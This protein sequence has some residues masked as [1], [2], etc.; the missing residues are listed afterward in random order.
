MGRT[1]IDDVIAYQIG[2]ELVCLVC[3][4]D[5][6]IENLSEDDLLEEHDFAD[7]YAFCDRCKKKIY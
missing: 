7:E 2:N 5:E 3:A 6:E 4:E 1:K